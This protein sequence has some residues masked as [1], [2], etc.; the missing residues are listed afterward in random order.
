MLQNIFHNNSK[1]M[2]RA[3]AYTRRPLTA[4]LLP[5]IGF[6]SGILNGFFGTGG[7]MVLSVGLRTAYPGE[8]RESMALATASMTVLSIVSTILYAASGHIG[9]KEILPVIVPAVF[10]GFLGA[11]LLGKI[12]HDAL[13]LLFGGM[14]LY[15]GLMILL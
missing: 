4:L 2:Y 14:L 8:D 9:S 1:N 12:R 13:D 11:L 6:L 7:G 15:S 10:G 3:R 5:L